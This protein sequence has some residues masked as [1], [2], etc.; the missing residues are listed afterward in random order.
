MKQI[1][2]ADTLSLSIQERI[3][4]VED[5]W[6]SIA[7]EPETVELTDEDKHIID[8][9]LETYYKNPNAGSPCEEVYKRIKAKRCL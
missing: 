8:E 4:L 6:D 9:R 1:T 2:V 3:A 7:A 5:I